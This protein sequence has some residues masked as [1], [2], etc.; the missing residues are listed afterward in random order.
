VKTTKQQTIC[1]PLKMEKCQ[2]LLYHLNGNLLGPT[3]G[4]FH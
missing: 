3:K 2:A 1:D 4:N